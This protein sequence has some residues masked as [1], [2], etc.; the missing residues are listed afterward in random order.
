LDT[1]AAEVAEKLGMQIE[2]YPADWATF[3]K[4]AGPRRNAVMVASGADAVLAFPLGRS[5]GTRHCMRLAEKAG[6]RVIN[7]GEEEPT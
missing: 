4:A 6:I 7:F 5:P 1:L 2:A 3:G